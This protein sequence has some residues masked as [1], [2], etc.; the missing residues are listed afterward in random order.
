MSI[1]TTKSR[2]VTHET[3]SFRLNYKDFKKRIFALSS[4]L[5]NQRKKLYPKRDTSIIYEETISILTDLLFILLANQRNLIEL[6]EDTDITLNLKMEV[7][8]LRDHDI[9]NEKWDEEL[10]SLIRELYKIMKETRLN[11]D[12][13]SILVED[14]WE[15][16]KLTVLANKNGSSNNRREKGSYYTKDEL[17]DV[18]VKNTIDPLC[19]NKSIKEILN[20]KIIDPAVGSGSF[21]LSALKRI[22]FHIK[23]LTKEDIDINSY[24]KEI[25][26]NCLYGVDI[27]PNA[28]KSAIYSLWIEV[29][30]NQFPISTIKR[31]FVEGDS[32]LAREWNL[33]KNNYDEEN[34]IL[35]NNYLVGKLLNG[36]KVKDWEEEYEELFVKKGNGKLL[37][38]DLIEKGRNSKTFIWQVSFKNVYKN[39]NGFDGV[40]GNPPWNKVKAH[41]KEFFIH[42]DLTIKGMQGKA[43]KK[44]VEEE[45]LSQE[46]Y[47]K[48]W[49][50]HKKNVSSYSKAVNNSPQFQHQAYVIN[51]RRQGGDRDLYKYF[52][53]LAYNLTCENG[54]V[55]FIIPAAFTHSEGTTGMR[56]LLFNQNNIQLLFTVENRDN[57]FPIDSRFKYA[58]LIFKKTKTGEA[59]IKCRFML[60]SLE[61]VNNS[62][63]NNELLK[64]PSDLI[65]L[66]SPNY[67]T[68]PDIKSQ[69]EVELLKKIY[70]VHPLINST[71]GWK[72]Q[73]NRELDMTND[74]NLFVHKEVINKEHKDYYPLYE[75]RMINQFDFAAKEYISGEGRQAKW[76]DLS[77]EAKKI[78]PHFYV[79]KIEVEKKNIEANKARPGYCDIAGQTNERAVQTALI[80]RHTV[81]GNKVPTV[82]ITP[83]DVAHNLLWI[84]LTNSFVFD[85][86]MR[87]RM[88]T[89]INFFHWNQLPLPLIDVF[90]N[91]GKKL[92]VNSAK[93][94]LLSP[95]MD[96]ER[97]ELIHFY[98]GE[99][100]SDEVKPVIYSNERQEIR[101]E[102]DALVA[103]VFGLNLPDI[104]F[105]LYQFPL[106]DRKQP[107]LPGDKCLNNRGEGSYI[108]RDLVLYHYLSIN[109]QPTSQ[110]I[111]EVYNQC[112]INIKEITG[113]I[114]R[115]D[116]RVNEAKELNAIAY[117]PGRK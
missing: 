25:I 100:N 11:T 37:N 20:L 52:L 80:P 30:E 108:T 10:H 68:L 2:D 55:G 94:S 22:L 16:S 79:Q 59:D 105:V 85:W 23:N 107:G 82:R 19:S 116:K 64:I 38:D 115:I 67:K 29:G 62:L 102:I 26:K 74:S 31:N 39:S 101:A 42:Y 84:A 21:I 36:D 44:Y 66:L 111:I 92:V 114:R 34:L 7:S 61:E 17:I 86:L 104:A 75:G 97:E 6:S 69:Y 60:R 14:S 58:L 93:L 90:S 110:D 63:K 54:Y 96:K 28:L 106:L 12:I 18:I 87:L 98:N 56:E 41:L 46:Y 117:V 47:K 78:L 32:L 35:L 8:N 70:K 3:S 48:L 33:K 72:I 71:R 50:D 57:I 9:T 73:F 103:N 77:W 13:L 43:L 112:N 5:F 65:N 15:K 27:N 89:T 83:N 53:E 91:C 40:I 113:D 1:K 76:G 88:S 81:A 24:K 109:N 45:F 95:Y 51:G 49:N 4:L 99:V